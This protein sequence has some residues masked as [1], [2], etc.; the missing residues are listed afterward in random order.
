MFQVEWQNC[1]EGGEPIRGAIV[2]IG[3]TL[4][5]AWVYDP[6][7]IFII[8]LDGKVLRPRDMR[9]VPAAGARVIG[10]L[11]AESLAATRDAM[12]RLREISEPFGEERNLGLDLNYDHI[13]LP[14]F[15]DGWQPI[16]FTDGTYWKFPS[17]SGGH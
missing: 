2:N 9:P 11:V 7:T 8:P 12:E 16:S 17:R 14:A 3:D 15:N 13:Q 5:V 6:E 10:R 1:A 4:G